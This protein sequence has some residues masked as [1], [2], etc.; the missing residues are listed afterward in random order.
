MNVLLGSLMAISMVARADDTEKTCNLWQVCLNHEELQ[1]EGGAEITTACSNGADV[2]VPYF[3][4]FAPSPMSSLGISDLASACPYL[5]P[6]DDMCCSS[7][8]AAIMGKYR[9]WQQLSF[10]IKF[11]SSCHFY[12]LFPLEQVFNVERYLILQRLKEN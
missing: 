1:Y 2:T 11:H 5:D 7:D 8:T 6:T 4:E 9:S 3:T 10:S 12:L